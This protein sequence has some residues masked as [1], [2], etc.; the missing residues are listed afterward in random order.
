MK[1][2][3]IMIHSKM[4][5]ATLLF[6]AIFATTT[7]SQVR[8]D[9]DKDVDFTKYKMYSFAGWQ[10]DSDQLMNDLDNNRILEAFKSEFDARE[11]T[12]VDNDADVKITLYVVLEDKTSVTAYTHYNGTMGYRGGWGYGMGG[13]GM[14]SSTTSYNEEEYTV[15]T[16]VV[17]MYEEDGKSLLWEGILTKTIKS[18]PKKREKSIPKNIAQVM[19]GYPV[20]PE[21]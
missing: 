19:K 2:I 15:G 6:C 14:A 8:S 16:L 7:F 10:K 3:I 12:L 1:K 13:V 5:I 4:V 20:K 18:N 9:F 17:D 21:K 11:M